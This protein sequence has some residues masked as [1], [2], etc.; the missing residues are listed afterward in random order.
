[1]HKLITLI[2]LISIFF[3]TGCFVIVPDDE[4]AGDS[5]L[6]DSGYFADGYAPSDD[7]DAEWTVEAASHQQLDI[8]DGR[9]LLECKER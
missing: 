2:T 1:M 8:I 4:K 3:L 9:V 7:A 6:Y 5:G